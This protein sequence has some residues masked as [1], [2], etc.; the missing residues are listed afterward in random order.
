MPS[1]QIWLASF[2]KVKEVFEFFK[3]HPNPSIA[4]TLKQSIEWVQ[5]NA[6]WV[7][8]IVGSEKNLVD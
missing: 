3:V 5:I 6:K 1:F 4:R 7:H 8:E 2:E